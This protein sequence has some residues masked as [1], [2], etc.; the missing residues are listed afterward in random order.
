MTINNLQCIELWMGGKSSEVLALY[1]ALLRYSRT[2]RFTDKLFYKTRVRQEFEQQRNVS[3]ADQ[4]F[5]IKVLLWHLLATFCS[6][7]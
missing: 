3:D 7:N 5:Y 6:Q 1:R 2:L 4:S